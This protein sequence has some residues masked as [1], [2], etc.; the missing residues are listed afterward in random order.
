KVATELLPKSPTELQMNSKYTGL[1]N[2]FPVI[3]KEIDSKFKNGNTFDKGREP[4]L[5][6]GCF[7]DVRDHIAQQL[8]DDELA[9]QNAAKQQT[10]EKQR[11][12]ESKKQQ[13]AKQKTPSSSHT[14]KRQQAAEPSSLP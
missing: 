9:R 10:Q 4:S 5:K 13:E 3:N 14:T 7:K 1:N 6:A 2:Q 11:L 12:E 8:M